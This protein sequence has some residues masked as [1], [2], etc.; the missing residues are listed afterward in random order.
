MDRDTI[1]IVDDEA[2][3]LAALNGT[4]EPYYRVRAANSG[5]RALQIAQTSPRPDLILLDILMPEMDGHKV[6]S[7]L[8]ADETTSDIPVI[9]ITA[10]DADED[11]EKGITMGAADYITKPINPAILLARVR[12]QLLVKQAKDFLVDKNK[13]LEAEVERRMAENQT[14]QNVSI[15]ALAH[16]AEIRD[17]E[18]GDHILR[19]QSYV[20]LLAQH[21]SDHPRFRN[22][23]NDNFIKLL[24]ESAPSTILVRSESPTTSF[25]NLANSARMSG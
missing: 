9:F 5:S 14:I 17:P 2:A 22:I 18:T 19:T 10:M 1:L 25:S 3:N 11:E 20:Q 6:L 16:L 23:I 7:K 21:L 15:R 12:S 13:F 8:R 4:L 24:T